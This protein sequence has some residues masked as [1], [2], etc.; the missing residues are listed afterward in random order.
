M[1]IEMNNILN[2]FLVSFKLTKKIGKVQ[3]F[4]CWAQYGLVQIVKNK[5]K[6]SAFH[7]ISLYCNRQMA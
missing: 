2:Y 1:Q 3:Y 6:H 5:K 7:E 4:F